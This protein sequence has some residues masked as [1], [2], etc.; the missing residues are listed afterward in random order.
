MLKL[1]LDYPY[2]FLILCVLVGSLYTLILYTKKTSW[3][4]TINKSLALIRFITVSFLLFLLL[5]PLLK[6][7]VNE[8]EKPIFVIGID[9]STSLLNSQST[10]QISNIFNQLDEI[11]QQLK[12]NGFNVEYRSLNQSNTQLKSIYFTEKITDLNSFLKNIQTEYESRNLAGLLLASDGNYNS[13]TSPAYFPYG[14]K[15]FTLGIGDTTIKQ[16]IILKNVLFNKIAYQG[17]K[18]PIVAEI[19]NKGFKGEKAIL[20]IRK[21]KKIISQKEVTF[22]NINGFNQVAFEIEADKKGINHFIVE[23]NTDANESIIINNKQD[24]F[25]DVIDGKQKILI[26]ALAPHPDIKAIQSVI[27]NNDNYELEIFIPNLNKLKNKKYDLIIVHQYFDRYNI[28]EKYIKQFKSKKIPILHIIGQQSNKVLA[29]NQDPDF[30]FKQIRNQWDNVS[31]VF[32]PDFSKFTF[33]LD[34]NAIMSQ[35]PTINIPYGDFQLTLDMD[36]I[37]YQQIGKIMINKPLLYVKESNDLKSGY[38]IS[39]GFWQWRLQEYA[40]NENTKVF[41]ELFSKLIQYLSTRINKKKFRVNTSQPEYF[42]NEPVLISTEIY[43]DIYEIIYNDN[44]NL[45]ITNEEGSKKEYSF[46]SSSS[47]FEVSGLPQGIYSYQA[48]LP[49]KNLKSNGKFVIKNLQLETLDQSA[50][51]NL[52]R[53]ISNNSEGTFYTTSNIHSLSN[54]LQNLKTKGII[55]TNEDFFALIN[56]KWLFFII[57]IL[58]SGEWFVR[59]YNGGY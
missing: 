13:G 11:G 6:Q 53:Q 50:N 21:K 2:W 43:N 3:N 28:T 1:N 25:V 12:N 34:N 49:D 33:N 45:T 8:I 15:I 36:I 14:Y 10:A 30:N 18:F 42:D 51:F 54:G 5:N 41:D 39:D 7:L 38:L 27:S 46:I 47:N 23:I 19:I 20:S 56:L 9:N 17:N 26:L 31:P 22:T 40:L 59:K 24:I 37:L 55:H 32:N 58:I 57:L 4:A 52:L 29:N 48:I 35:Y 16:D 44:V